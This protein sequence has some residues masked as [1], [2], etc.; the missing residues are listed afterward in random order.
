MEAS[1][2][3]FFVGIYWGEILSYISASLD[4]PRKHKKTPTIQKDVEVSSLK[5]IA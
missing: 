4:A 5:R 1:V 3:I 2:S